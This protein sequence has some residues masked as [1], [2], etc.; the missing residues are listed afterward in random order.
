MA[1]G[2]CRRRSGHLYHLKRKDAG[3]KWSVKTPPPPP[4]DMSKHPRCLPANQECITSEV[5]RPV[6]R[7]NNELS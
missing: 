6:R 1:V 7:I 3:G 5:G 2:G 4:T